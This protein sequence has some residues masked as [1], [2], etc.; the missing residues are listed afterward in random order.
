MSVKILAEVDSMEILIIVNDEI[1]QISHSPN[2]AVKQVGSFAG[3]RLAPLEPAEPRN[4]AAAELKMNHICCGAF[5]FSAVIVG[6]P[7]PLSLI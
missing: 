2:Q 3:V 5:G 4:G 6:F 1:D 7:F